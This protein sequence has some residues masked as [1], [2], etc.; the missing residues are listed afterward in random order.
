MSELRTATAASHPCELYA[1][2]APPV[3]IRTQYHHSKPVFLQNELY[4]RIVYPADTWLC[5]LCHDS[6]HETLDWMLG[7]GRQPNPLPGRKTYAEAERTYDWYVA[8]K[9]RLG[10]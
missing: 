4:G 2:T 10:L 8:E 1:H 5:G 3:V 7:K 6:V 9:E